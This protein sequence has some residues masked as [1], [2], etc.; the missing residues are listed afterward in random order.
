MDLDSDSK[1]YSNGRR[2]KKPRG[3]K[4]NGHYNPKPPYLSFP[5]SRELYFT[6]LTSLF[7][8]IILF[9]N[10]NGIVFLY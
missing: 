3:P 8:F 10:L 5:V 4:V 6:L 1:T 7:S 2:V 9:F